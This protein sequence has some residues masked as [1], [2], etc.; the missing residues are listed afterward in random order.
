M[1][2]EITGTVTN[3][4]KKSFIKKNLNLV[5]IISIILTISRCNVILNLTHKSAVENNPKPGDY[6][7]LDNFPTKDEQSILKIKQIKTNEIIFFIP[8][9][10]FLNY[11]QETKHSVK[12]LD[13]LGEMYGEDTMIISKNK[14]KEMEANDSFTGKMKNKPMLIDRF[15]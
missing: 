5:I 11:N 13:N 2:K 14:L 4:S 15:R 10:E 12:N 3:N 8:K 1:K 9:K 6:Y 7:V